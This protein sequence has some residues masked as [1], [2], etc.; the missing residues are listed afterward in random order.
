MRATGLFM[1]TGSDDRPVCH[2]H[3]AD[4]GI[5]TNRFPAS[6]RKPES[7]LHEEDVLLDVVHRRDGDL[8]DRPRAFDGDVAA[9]TRRARDLADAV[10]FFGFAIGR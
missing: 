7:L 3:G 8:R 2:D 1:E 10:F 9:G 5:R 6:S 4:H